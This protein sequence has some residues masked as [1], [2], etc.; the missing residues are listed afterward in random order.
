VLDLLSI[1]D[2][3]AARREADQ[4]DRHRHDPPR[5]LHL[6]SIAPQA[7]FGIAGANA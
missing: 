6:R 2:R 3:H 4:L 5:D 7:R 1:A